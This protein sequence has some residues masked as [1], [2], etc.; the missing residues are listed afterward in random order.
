M[1]YGGICQNM[2]WNSPKTFRIIRTTLYIRQISLE[3]SDW[4]Y[5]IGRKSKAFCLQIF[6]N[7]AVSVSFML[8]TEVRYRFVFF[9]L[10]RC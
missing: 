10:K 2:S 3:F 6:K 5:K 9:R 8:S 4:H 1:P 7:A